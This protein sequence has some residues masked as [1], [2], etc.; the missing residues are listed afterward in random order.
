MSVAAT[1]RATPRGYVG[2]NHETIGSDITSVLKCLTFPRSVLGDAM[3]DRLETV[4]DDN[5]YPIATLLDL[6]EQLDAKLG[7]AG[8]RKMG[9]AL[10]KNSHEA[11]VKAVITSARN[12]VEG[13]DG[14]YRH[15]NRGLAIGG[16]KV[17]DFQPGR[18]E[19]EKTTPHHCAMEEGILLEGLTM[20]G[21]TARIEQPQCLRRGGEL[22]RLVIT[23]SVTDERWMGR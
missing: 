14:M 20:V 1:L 10:F 8:L 7:E 16:W 21:V 13:I 15:A 6:M 22:C 5:W 17:A 2:R 19:L 4:R 12:I 9:R 11:R 3:V 23:S 18:A